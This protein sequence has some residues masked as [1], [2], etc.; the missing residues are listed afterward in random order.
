MAMSMWSLEQ[1][2]KLANRDVIED[3]STWYKLQQ[4]AAELCV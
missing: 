3:W 2:E 1:L 4:L